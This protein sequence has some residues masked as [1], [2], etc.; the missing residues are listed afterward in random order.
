MDSLTTGKP[1]SRRDGRGPDCT[2][3]G[4]PGLIQANAVTIDMLARNLGSLLHRPVIDHTGLA[5]SFDADLHYQPEQA[6]LTDQLPGPTDAPSIFTAVQE[7]L[8]LKLM[9]DRGPV[10]VQV[11]DHVERPSPD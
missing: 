4:G 6:P 2:F 8:G 10:A 7:Q 11:I 3:G 5:G 1:V 9:P